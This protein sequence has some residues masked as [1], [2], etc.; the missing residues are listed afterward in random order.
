VA[1]TTTLPAD[2]LAAAHCVVPGL[3]DLSVDTL[4]RVYREVRG[5]ADRPG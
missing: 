1:L 2:E 5:N 4:R 3:G